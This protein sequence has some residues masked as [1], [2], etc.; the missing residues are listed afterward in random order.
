ML[1]L[2]S[3]IRTKTVLDLAS[4]NFV[5]SDLVLVALT[6]TIAAFFVTFLKGAC[7]EGRKCWK[8]AKFE[9][10]RVIVVSSVVVVG[11]AAN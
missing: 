10:I 5:N 7:S 4:I 9:W 2:Q 6:W 11:P 8:C 1:Q 3:I